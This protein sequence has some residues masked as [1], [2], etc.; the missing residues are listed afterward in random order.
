MKEDD[1]VRARDLSETDKSN[2]SAREFKTTVKDIRWA[3]GKKKGRFQEGP[4]IEIKDSEMKNVVTE[5]GNRKEE[6]DGWINDTE[7][8]K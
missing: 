4:Y 5:I 2:T 6:A 7:D 8:T 1:N 3:W